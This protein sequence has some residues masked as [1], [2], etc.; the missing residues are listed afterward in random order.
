MLQLWQ[1]KSP[2]ALKTIFFF[3]RVKKNVTGI[4]FI[5][6]LTFSPQGMPQKCCGKAKKKHY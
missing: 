6:F 5:P 2:R 4:L 3:K 1:K